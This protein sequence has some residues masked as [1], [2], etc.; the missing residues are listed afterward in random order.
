MSNF[1]TPTTAVVFHSVNKRLKASLCQI[2]CMNSVVPK[3]MKCKNWH[4][5]G[6]S[7]P[8]FTCLRALLGIPRPNKGMQFCYLGQSILLDSAVRKVWQGRV[9][10]KDYGTLHGQQNRVKEKNMVKKQNEWILC[11]YSHVV[12]RPAWIFLQMCVN[13]RC[14][15]V[16]SVLQSSCSPECKPNEV[17]CLAIVLYEVSCLVIVLYEW[18]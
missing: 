15:D 16:N 4:S 1:W 6:A 11:K 7:T 2:L 10:A 9:S 13:Q 8:P 14:V 12:T 17:S 18:I 3:K 5:R